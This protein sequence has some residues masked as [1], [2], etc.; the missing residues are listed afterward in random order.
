MHHLVLFGTLKSGFFSSSYITVFID[1]WFNVFHFGIFS[2]TCVLNQTFPW[3]FLRYQYTRIF[4]SFLTIPWVVAKVSSIRTCTS[5]CW[6]MWNYCILLLNMFV[7][8]LGLF[9]F[10]CHKTWIGSPIFGIIFK[11]HVNENVCWF[12]DHF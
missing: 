7:Q 11:V 9:L 4:R 12:K 2:Y 5:Y 1:P 8:V 3:N 6:M 10:C